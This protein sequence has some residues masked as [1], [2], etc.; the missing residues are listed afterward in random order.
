MAIYISFMSHLLPFFRDANDII[1][2]RSNC[3]MY[4][5]ILTKYAVEKKNPLVCG[6]IYARYL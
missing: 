4:R 1:T 3:P 2:C 5:I 6:S